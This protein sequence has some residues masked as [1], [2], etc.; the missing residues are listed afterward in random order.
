VARISK[1]VY[2]VDD[3][4]TMD[5]RRYV[6]LYGILKVHITNSTSEAD[7]T[8]TQ[9]TKR[10]HDAVGISMAG[11][12]NLVSSDDDT[13]ALVAG[14]YSWIRKQLNGENIQI[15]LPGVRYYHVT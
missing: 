11:V 6:G 10:S 1:S 8:T 4:A 14:M 2:E 9:N 13:T 12:A 7:Q 3:T 15:R 5:L